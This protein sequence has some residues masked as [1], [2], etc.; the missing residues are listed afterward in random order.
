MN[1]L[2]FRGIVG[3]MV[4]LERF[5]IDVEEKGNPF[6]LG[7]LEK[8]HFRLRLFFDRHIVSLQFSSTMKYQ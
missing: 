4:S 1:R 8:Q 6:I 7:L 5:L 2:L 3:I